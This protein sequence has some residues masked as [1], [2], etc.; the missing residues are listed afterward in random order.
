MVD[1]INNGEEGLSVR[2]KLNTVIDRTNTLNGIENQV[3]ANKNL[4]QQNSAR[5]DKEIQDRIDGDA[6]LWDH[7]NDVE[8]QLENLDVSVLDDKIDQEILD[9]LEG[10]AN[11][12]GQ[13]DALDADKDGSVGWDEVTGKPDTYPPGAHNHSISDIDGL[14]EA[15]EI[16]P[17]DYEFTPNTLVLR[18]NSGN[19]KGKKVIGQTL[20]MTTGGTTDIAPRPDDTI[21]Y[22]SVS[23]QIYKNSKEGMRDA[24]DVY[25]KS[26]A[27]NLAPSNT[28]E[29]SW[30]YGASASRSGDFTTRNANWITAT[31]IT[32]SK[33]DESGYEHNFALMSEGDI[34]FVQAPAGGAEYSIVSKIV[35]ASDCAFTV[36][37]ISSYG[38]FP[39]TGNS[40]RFN[41]IPQ[42]STGSS[43]HIGENPPAD[44]QE[45][46]QWMEVPADG[47]AT[48]WIYDGGKW[49]QQ[50]GGK[51]GAAGADGNIQ[52]ATEQG[53]VATWDDSA[54][55]WTPDSSLAIDSSGNVGIGTGAPAAQ[56]E[57][58]GSNT[59]A[60][61]RG[62]GSQMINVNF[63]ETPSSAEIDFRNAGNF[64][65]SKQG[66][67]ALTIDSSGDATFS[68]NIHYNWG[69]GNGV[70]SEDDS[71]YSALY[72]GSSGQTGGGVVCY[73][74]D[75]AALA[76]REGGIS[77]FTNNFTEQLRIDATGDATF[78]GA[79]LVG[80]GTDVGSQTNSGVRVSSGAQVSKVTIQSTDASGANN[81]V[82]SALKGTKET[83][84][85]SA[86]GDATFSGSVNAAGLVVNG[87]IIYNNS[88]SGHGI[89]FNTLAEN[90][91]PINNTGSLTT[92]V[93]DIG[94][95]ANKFKNG[96]FSGS[97]T[98][99]RM[100][101]DGHLVMS[102]RDL[103]ETLSTLRNA[104]KDETTLEGLRDAIGNAVGGLVEKF[105]AMQSAATQEIE[106]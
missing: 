67:P 27:D 41:F 20:Q 16:P 88:A 78:S 39:S 65:I 94:G 83:A 32:F 52:D 79:V 102:T 55:Q 5:I 104:T 63:S 72:G 54:K 86:S 48:M 42:V 58:K 23:N 34:I 57:V 25:S 3:E 98:S 90:I 2:E 11:L 59:N 56:F 36:N 93:T 100:I 99:T 22:S 85:I 12:Q 76:G 71:N 17:W 96:Y 66:S 13:I 89:R 103:I 80:G 46:Q 47:D 92:D 91:L 87:N 40:C 82:F 10:D 19:L 9:R 1:Y 73:G 105:E 62:V 53:V 7:V 44:P 64:H 106:S 60:R 51:D 74:N 29:G 30:L 69:Y 61:F 26:E 50:P 101:A 68:K 97:V 6:E 14:E 33:F 95:S 75:Y 4:S 8:D 18:D 84:F 45:G 38:S 70:I 49:L 43:V 77:F 24:L 28:L 15:L 21:F 35:Q 37:L 31:S 81:T